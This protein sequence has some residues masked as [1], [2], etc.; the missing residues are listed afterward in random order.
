MFNLVECSVRCQDGLP[1]GGPGGGSTTNENLGP[2]NS[3]NQKQIAI[4]VGCGAGALVLIAVGIFL[5]HR[6]RKLQAVP[7]IPT[8]DSDR[9]SEYLI[10]KLLP[11]TPNQLY[12]VYA[13]YNA[14]RSDELSLFPNQ[15][16]VIRN[17]YADGWAMGTDLATGVAGVFPLVCLIPDRN[18][19]SAPRRLLEIP[20]RTQ[21]SIHI[22]MVLPP[23]LHSSSNSTVGTPNP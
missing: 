8:L 14:R 21:A 15:V 2:G 17:T 20:E 5:I 10:P 4:I 6:H 18:R 16:V 11:R 7:A 3:I 12:S 19:K 13:P 1:C 22:N 9:S 23:L